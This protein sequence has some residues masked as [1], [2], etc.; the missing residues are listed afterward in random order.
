MASDSQRIQQ[1]TWAG[2]FCLFDSKLR[3]SGNSSILWGVL[4]LLIGTAAISAHSN[5]GA[6][7]FIL[8]LA[9]VAAGVYE[10][11]VRDPQVILISAATLA[12]LALWNFA[13][14][15]LASMGKL[16]LA[17][18]GR[19]LYWAI[20]QAWGAYATWKTYS[21]YKVLMEKSDPLTVQQ[22]RE[23]V[24]EL[25]KAKPDQSVDLV[26][27]EMNAGFVAGTKC[28]RL[29]PVEDLYLVA[30]Y[31]SQLRSLQLEELSFVPRNEVTLTT[32]GEKW[33]SKKIKASVQLGPLKL[34]K[35]TITPEMASRIS[36]GA[37]VASPELADALSRS[38]Y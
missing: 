8:G 16:H 5:W 14:I 19:T 12:G 10:R 35:V 7:S 36:P 38:T 18:G 15:A 22:V 26:Q 24:N 13:L 3:S 33:M 30:R 4:N 6:V 23:S 37:S 32:D 11:K 17:L 27:F 31:K 28:Y 25:K 34:D 21:T 20:A 2:T 1:L 29:K 9:L